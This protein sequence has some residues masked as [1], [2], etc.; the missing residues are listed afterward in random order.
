MTASS[1]PAV[2]GLTE[3]QARSRLKS[4]GYNELPRP[5]RRTPFRIVFEVL[6]EPMLALLLAAG[7]SICCSAT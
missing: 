1:T 5:D 6:R 3:Q 2:T 7:S 4:E